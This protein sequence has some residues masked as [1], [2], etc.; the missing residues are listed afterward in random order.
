[1]SMY[2]AVSFFGGFPEALRTG[3]QPVTGEPEE[4]SLTGILA[5]P[6]ICAPKT[7]SSLTWNSR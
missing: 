3:N 4:M 1:M 2:R 7:S 6:M 5:V